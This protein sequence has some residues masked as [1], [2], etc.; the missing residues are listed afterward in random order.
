MS[1][2]DEPEFIILMKEYGDEKEIKK[3]ILKER[4]KVNVLNTFYSYGL[5]DTPMSPLSIAILEQMSTN[6]LEFL[7]KQGADVNENYNEEELDESEDMDE[8]D[9][10]SLLTYNGAKSPL[11]FVMMNN[12]ML[13]TVKMFVENGA[14][15]TLNVLDTANRVKDESPEFLEFLREELDIRQH[16]FISSWMNQRTVAT[17]DP[18]EVNEYGDTPL[19]I[20]S[21]Q[22]QLQF[23]KTL[24]GMGANI[25]HQNNKSQTP[26]HNASYNNHIEVVNF[27]LSRGANPNIRDDNGNRYNEVLK[28][29]N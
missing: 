17:I 7:I 10:L 1:L 2:Y 15:I 28:L 14:E 27:L 16:D 22:G 12:V 24:I 9:R 26:L 23:V 13:D 3:L 21:N 11:G 18:F 4:N 6:F 8:E 29:K 19:I 5:S 20:A 25:N